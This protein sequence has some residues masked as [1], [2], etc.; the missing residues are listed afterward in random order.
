M[1][2][3]S[4]NPTAV[5]VQ[6]DGSNEHEVIQEMTRLTGKLFVATADFVPGTYYVAFLGR[7]HVL[8]PDQFRAAQGLV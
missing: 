1:T 4:F 7:V 8:M 2:N 6:Y 3:L 5:A